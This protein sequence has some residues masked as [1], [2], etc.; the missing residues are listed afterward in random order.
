MKVSRKIPI[1]NIY[2]LL[3]YAWNKLEER[4]I[5]EVHGIESSNLYDLFAKVLA[6]GL[7]HLFK[8][9]IG[10]DYVEESEDLRCLRGKLDFSETLKRNLF[11]KARA[12]C[13]HDE[14]SYNVLH[15]QI[16]KSTLRQLIF[17][18]KLDSDLKNELAG[19]HRKLH[20][21][22][23]IQLSSIVFSRIQ[24]NQNN[25]FYDFLLRICALIYDNLLVS[26][27]SGKSKFR[28]F[29]EDERQMA[30][31][32]EEFVRNFYR[33][34]AAGCRV[35][36]EEISWDAIPLDEKST[37]YLPKMKTDISIERNGS[38]MIID[39]KYYK[40]TLEKSRY[41]KE[42]IRSAHLY[43]LFSY[44]QN[45]EAKGGINRFCAGTLIYP[46]VD[47]EIR[48][49]YQIRGHKVMIRTLNL[50]QHWQGIHQELMSLLEEI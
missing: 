6:N 42:T 14:F 47:Q 5:V 46:T 45:L 24:L 4:D 35:S 1:Q 40:Q 19:L 10:R 9:G 48:L 15:N 29:F 32:F 36:S 37:S 26:E 13:I 21:I 22:D 27:G 2:Y 28:D 7:N 41:E 50:N 11:I 12:H 8:R 30:S 16:L 3:S 43:Q 18:D 23:D 38:K 44:L 39:T 17:V 33:L 20:D 49:N 31:L 25:A 34:E